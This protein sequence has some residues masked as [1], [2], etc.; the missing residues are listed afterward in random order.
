MSVY[1][2]KHDSAL[3]MR[4]N[5][6]KNPR[7]SQDYED[8]SASKVQND[9]GILKSTR[10]GQRRSNFNSPKSL[11]KKF[12]QA[13]QEKSGMTARSSQGGF[14]T[15]RKIIQSREGDF[16]NDTTQ[17]AMNKHNS[18]CSDTKTGLSGTRI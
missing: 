16:M 14:S 15:R 9:T 8:M 11:K 2:N 6:G 5:N 3:T 13:S 12:E 7:N 1:N 10:D 4:Q 18:E 17:R